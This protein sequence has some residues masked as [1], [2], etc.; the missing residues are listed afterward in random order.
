MKFKGCNFACRLYAYT[1]SNPLWFL[2][3]MYAHQNRLYCFVLN[4]CSTIQKSTLNHLGCFLKV[5][6]KNYKSLYLQP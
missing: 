1:V 4:M 2:H 5:N 6:A 3:W